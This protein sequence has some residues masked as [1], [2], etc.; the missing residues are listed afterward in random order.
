MINANEDPAAP[1]IDSFLLFWAI[2]FPSF[3][4]GKD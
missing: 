4:T 2:E 1:L 3:C